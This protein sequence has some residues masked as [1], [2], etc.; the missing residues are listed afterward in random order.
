MSSQGAAEKD[1]RPCHWTYMRNV[2]VNR[3]LTE[4]IAHS[5][6]LQIEIA[7]VCFVFMV[8]KYSQNSVFHSAPRNTS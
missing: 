7:L 4:A 3:F 5:F 6:R 8:K 1:S 2:H